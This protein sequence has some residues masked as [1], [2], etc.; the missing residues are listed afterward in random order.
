MSPSAA[1]PPI[2]IAAGPLLYAELSADFTT[3]VPC[4]DASGEELLRAEA[5][6]RDILD[7]HPGQPGE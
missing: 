7:G 2:S 5:D 6:R 4:L 1:P 3:Q